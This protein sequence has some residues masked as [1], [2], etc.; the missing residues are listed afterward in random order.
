M[1]H[2]TGSRA[3]FS[4]E[5]IDF[6]LMQRTIMQNE[7]CN[8][9]QKKRKMLCTLITTLALN[10]CTK[11]NS[12]SRLRKVHDRTLQPRIIKHDT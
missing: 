3:R 10:A 6:L 11:E 12:F 1:Y 2:H 8:E 7:K 9:I 4:M 5:D